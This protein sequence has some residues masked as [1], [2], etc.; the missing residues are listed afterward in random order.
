MKPNAIGKIKFLHDC[1]QHTLNAFLIPDNIKHLCLKVIRC[2]EA[3]FTVFMYWIS[4]QKLKW[5]QCWHLLMN[6]F[7][8]ANKRLNL[9]CCI[10]L[11]LALYHLKYSYNQF[12]SGRNLRTSPIHAQL[13][14]SGAMFGE[15]NAYERAMWFVPDTDEGK[16]LLCI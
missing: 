16:V 8:L 10:F 9:N 4:W 13:K 5:S 7:Y 11:F 12:S 3:L 15:T 14:V 6:K 1:L 2:N